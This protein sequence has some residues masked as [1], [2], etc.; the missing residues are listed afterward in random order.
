MICYTGY[1][2]SFLRFFFSFFVLETP[3]KNMKLNKKR[4]TKKQIPGKGAAV[5]KLKE[6]KKRLKT[7]HK[8]QYLLS[9]FMN[10]F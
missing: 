6:L 9:L 10:Y 2:I 7:F 3:I 1:I 4:E 8:P 5:K